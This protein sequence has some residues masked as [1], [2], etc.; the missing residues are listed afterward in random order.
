MYP[1]VFLIQ[2]RSEIYSGQ[3]HRNGFAVRKVSCAS[4]EGWQGGAFTDRG[5]RPLTASFYGVAWFCSH[6]HTHGLQPPPREFPSLVR[7]VVI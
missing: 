1:E 7:H 5:F 3:G 6:A 4:T 2:G